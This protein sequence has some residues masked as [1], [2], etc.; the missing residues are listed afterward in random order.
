MFCSAYYG[1]SLKVAGF[2][3]CFVVR[4]EISYKRDRILLT[5]C[6]NKVTI[7]ENK[8]YPLKFFIQ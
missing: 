5:H 7:H 8:E 4:M 3:T 1:N 6:K 2:C